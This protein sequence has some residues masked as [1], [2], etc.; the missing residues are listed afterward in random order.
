MEKCTYPACNKEA[1][2]SNQCQKHERM[3]KAIAESVKKTADKR[4]M[5]KEA[6]YKI[7]F[8]FEK[9]GYSDCSS[10]WAYIE[11]IADVI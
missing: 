8:E 5:A 1:E 4:K 2:G 9:L 6:L 11:D 10:I 3:E 7:S